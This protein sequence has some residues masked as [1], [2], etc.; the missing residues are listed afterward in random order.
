MLTF[1]GKELSPA[2]VA[3][4]GSLCLLFVIGLIAGG[5]AGSYLLTLSS[6]RNNEISQA[7]QNLASGKQTCKAIRA[8]DNASIHA[9]FYDPTGKNSYGKNLSSAIHSL[10]VNS[11]CP[12]II[13][14]Q[15]RIS[16]TGHITFTG[17]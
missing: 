17:K 6:I 7:Q 3:V 12:A 1:K 11:E 4:I 15:Y 2:A 5:I 13:A 14:G 10:Y 16:N 8:M 9:T